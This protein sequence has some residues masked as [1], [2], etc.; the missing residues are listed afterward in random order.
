MWKK[1][2]L[3]LVLVLC[4]A[5]VMTACQQKE[6]FPTTVSQ[7]Y[8]EQPTEAPQDVQNIF[9]ET[10][11]PQED[12]IDWDEYD[13]SREEGG[14]QEATGLEEDVFNPTEAP[15]VK[16]E[17]AGATP[18]LIDP[19]DKPTATPLPPLTFTYQKYEAKGLNLSFEAPAGWEP[20]ETIPNTFILTN[21]MPEMDYEAKLSIRKEPTEGNKNLSKN[22]LIKAVK[23]ELDDI[24]KQGGFQ[25]FEKS[26]TAGR[27]FMNTDA[28][29]AN[30]TGT[31]LDN[32]AEKG[33]KIAGRVIIACSNKTLYILHV[34]YP[35][36]YTSTY[37]EQ[38]YNKFRHSVKTLSATGN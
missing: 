28:I 36:G 31:L 5:A 32:G 24:R 27:K 30:Y 20:N 25:K 35:Q 2:I 22:E 34:S 33:A 4:A 10:A 29:Y 11:V 18:V 14:D 6:T 17:Y 26:Q 13:P 16:G 9:G 19:I 1:R 21:P 37:V 8:A 15:T 3:C 38:V 12:D 23:D 7:E